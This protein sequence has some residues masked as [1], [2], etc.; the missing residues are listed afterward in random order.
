MFYTPYAGMKCAEDHFN[1]GMLLKVCFKIVGFQKP[2]TGIPYRSRP[3][4]PWACKHIHKGCTCYVSFLY[5]PRAEVVIFIINHGPFNG[6]WPFNSTGR[7]DFVLYDLEND[8]YKIYQ[9]FPD[10][11]H[12]I[13]TRA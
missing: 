10:F 3:P 12:K 13:K 8:D 7:H 9:M 5:A 4:G 1:M 11:C 6:P 2:N